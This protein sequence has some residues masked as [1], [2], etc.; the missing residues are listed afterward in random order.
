MHVLHR[1]LIRLAGVK[2]HRGT[3]LPDTV[4]TGGVIV[5]SALQTLVQLATVLHE[6]ELI[7][8][9]ESVTGTWHPPTLSPT[10]ITESLHPYRRHRGA[11]TLLRVLD[12]VRTGVASPKETELRLN[13]VAWGYPE[14]TV[15]HKVWIESIGRH[16]TPDLAYEE[17]RTGI[18]YEGAHHRTS[19]RQ[20]EKDEDR[21]CAFRSA[22]WFIE[23]I[24]DSG[25][26]LDTMDTVMKRFADLE[27]G[28][29]LSP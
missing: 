26:Y 4:T 8:A 1:S 2:C 21:R 29:P 15:G 28:R 3:Q 13:I 27:A 14:P 16:L 7:I 17:V 22:G 25:K 23:R 9:V 12:R 6:K 18:E 20:F 10:E 5:V 11:L 24:Y 19:R